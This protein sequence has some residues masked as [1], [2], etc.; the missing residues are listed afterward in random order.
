MSSVLTWDRPA[1]LLKPGLS[2]HAVS[3]TAFVR[4]APRARSIAGVCWLGMALCLSGC[5]G[6]VFKPVRADILGAWKAEPF[7]FSSV[8]IPLSPN[9]E[10]TDKALILIVP[11]ARQEQPINAITPQ[12]DSVVLD[13]KGVPLDLRFYFENRDRMYFKVPILTTKIFFN[14]MSVSVAR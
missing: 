8:R 13:L 3:V 7:D 5:S 6:N 14:R 9:F 11:N 4:I 1:G 12:D 2:G 10:V